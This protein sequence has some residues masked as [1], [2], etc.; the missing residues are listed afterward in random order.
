[1]NSPSHPK[2][3]P[4]WDSAKYG[5]ADGL[6]STIHQKAWKGDRVL[7]GRSE[8]MGLGGPRSETSSF[9]AREV[10]AGCVGTS[11]RVLK[12]FRSTVSD[13]SSQPAV[14]KIFLGTVYLIQGNPFSL[15]VS[16]REDYG[17]GPEVR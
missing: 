16:F 14:R 7:G 9:G 17:E 12:V 10:A 3:N 11:M 15:W 2:L 5:G 4:I 8:G 1:M 6:I 13:A